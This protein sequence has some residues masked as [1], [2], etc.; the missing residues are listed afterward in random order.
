MVARSNLL[1][2]AV[3][4]LTIVAGPAQGDTFLEKCSSTGATRGALAA[5]SA[6]EIAA[7]N[8]LRRTL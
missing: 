7:L 1:L 2:A 5:S 8:A 6:D 4:I 3:G